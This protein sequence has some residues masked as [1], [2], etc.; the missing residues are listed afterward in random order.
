MVGINTHLCSLWWD[1]CLISAHVG[2][3]CATSITVSSCVQVFCYVRKSLFPWSYSPP[4]NLTVFLSSLAWIEIEG[5]NWGDMYI[6]ACC[7]VEGAC[8]KKLLWKDLRDALICGYSIYALYLWIQSLEVGLI[9][10]IF[11][12][13]IVFVFSRQD[14]DLS[15]HR[16]LISLSVPAMS[17]I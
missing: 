14:C 15:S 4:L 2:Y 7:P 8:N 9:P 5:R 10:C 3:V 11:S 6:F 13:I 1:F 16:F 17:S 12:R